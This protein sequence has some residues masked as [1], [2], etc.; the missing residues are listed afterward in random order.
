[1]ILHGK[2]RTEL[3]GANRWTTI[4]EMEVIAAVEALRSIPSG[5]QVRLHSDSR[6]LI[7]GMSYLAQRW[8]RY[9]WKNSR[10]AP[11]QHQ[12][13]WVELM[14]LNSLHKVEWRWLQ[15]HRG[16]WIQ[17][18]ADQLAYLEARAALDGE[19]VAA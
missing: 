6:Y 1:M 18:R 2:K 10:G 15:G 13:L 11:I 16:H 9:G 4:S 7:D 3:S 19:S 12:A 8:R 5:Q 14:S 17:G